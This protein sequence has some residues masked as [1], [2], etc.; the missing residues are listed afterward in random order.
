MDTPIILLVFITCYLLTLC[1]LKLIGFKQKVVSEHY[2][3]CCP[4]CNEAL[5]RVR[6]NNFDRIIN[7]ITF[8]VFGFKRYLCN[9]C[10]WQGL[11]WQKKFEK[12]S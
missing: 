11:R 4:I 8:Q 12:K 3:N 6:R 10:D 5:E 1:F 2:S 7:L 9:N